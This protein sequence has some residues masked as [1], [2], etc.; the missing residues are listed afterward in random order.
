MEVIRGVVRM[1]HNASLLYVPFLSLPL[2]VLILSS[3]ER[4][5]EV[6]ELENNWDLFRTL[7]SLVR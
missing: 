6:I 4:E 5:L 3:S 7:A 1:L 2:W